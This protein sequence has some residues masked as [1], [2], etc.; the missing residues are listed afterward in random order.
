MPHSA[1]AMAM[2]ALIWFMVWVLGAYVWDAIRKA[3]APTLPPLG[4]IG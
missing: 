1:A 4:Q 2:E 3:T